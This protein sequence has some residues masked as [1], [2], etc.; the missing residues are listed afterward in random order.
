LVRGGHL[1][2]AAAVDLS[3]STGTSASIISKTVYTSRGGDFLS[4][5]NVPGSQPGSYRILA[6]IQG[7]P[8]AS[9]RYTVISRA[10]LSV[11]VVSANGTDTFTIVGRRFIS[12]ERLFI[13][14]IPMSGPGVP[15]E[16]AN[17]RCGRHGRFRLIRSIASLPP[18]Q[19]DL[20]A[21]STDAGSLQIAD[22]V[23]SVVT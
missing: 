14:A 23:F 8:I 18:G 7:V 4:Q 20:R 15:T 9:A 10:I 13:L 2:A 19:Y 17:V 1:P 21:L 12:H 22:T 11:D 5:F 6:E 3:W 16:L